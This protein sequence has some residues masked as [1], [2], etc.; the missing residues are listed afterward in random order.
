MTRRRRIAAALAAT[1]AGAAVSACA[2]TTVAGR[3][4]APAGVATARTAA[5]T[6]TVAAPAQR[7][8]DVTGQG[9]L[10]P[11]DAIDDV[12]YSGVPAPGVGV[13]H[14]P[15]TGDTMGGCTLGPAVVTADGGSGWITAGHCAI[16]ARAAEQWLETTPAGATTPMGT[17]V[18]V[19][20]DG[21]VDSALIPDPGAPVTPLLAET[22]PIAGVL[23]AAGAAALPVGVPV[24]A[25]GARSGVVCGPNEGVGGDG[26]IVYG[27]RTIRGDSGAPV[28]VVDAATR[29]ATL[30]GVH[31][32]GDGVS[33][34]WA[35]LL[36]P[37]L[38]RLRARAV[39]DAAAAAAVAGRPGCS[40]RVTPAR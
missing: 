1:L 2:T 35:T 38:D 28:F 29:T 37:A 9:Q 5:A 34:A 17:A 10:A 11:R 3:P 20:D 30:V 6:P 19:V 7:Y 23:T 31:K 12:Q 8:L 39:V 21:P 27:A 22:W 15:D 33:A 16:G 32:G 14:I 24:C 25:L 26:R 13:L 36:D 18:G 4:A 40:P